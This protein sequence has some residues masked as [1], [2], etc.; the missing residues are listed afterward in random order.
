MLATQCI[1]LTRR[2][3]PKILASTHSLSSYRQSETTF[4]LIH[5]LTE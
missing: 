1:F 2:P 4:N 5:A 3:T